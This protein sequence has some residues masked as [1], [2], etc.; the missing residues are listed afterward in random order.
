MNTRFWALYIYL[1]SLWSYLESES[2]SMNMVTCYLSN[3]IYEIHNR[4]VHSQNSGNIIPFDSSLVLVGLAKDVWYIIFPNHATTKVLF[5]ILAIH[6]AA[7]SEWSSIP[8]NHQTFWFVVVS[9]VLLS[10]E[11]SKASHIWHL[12]KQ[13]YCSCNKSLHDSLS[14]KA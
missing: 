4:T 10:P 6:H 9:S 3:G 2:S 14:A 13:H 11:V 7:L 12:L 5:D 8:P 1:L